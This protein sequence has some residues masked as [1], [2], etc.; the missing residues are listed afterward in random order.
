MAD[1][2][3]GFDEATLRQMVSLVSL[4]DCVPLIGLCLLCPCVVGLAKNVREIGNLWL[5]DAPR[6]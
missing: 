5:L 1:E 6:M 4:A 3:D 2:F